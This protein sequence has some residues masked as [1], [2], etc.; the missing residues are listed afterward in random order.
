MASS[1]LEPTRFVYRRFRLCVLAAILE[2]V[3][4]R[5]LERHRSSLFVRC[6]ERNR[7]RFGALIDQFL[8]GAGARGLRPITR[9]GSGALTAEDARNREH[10][11]LASA[12]K[13]ACSWPP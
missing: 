4:D 12:P 9:N 7:R 5:I 2:R 1:T 11:S 8:E 3:S 13:T 6:G 10:D